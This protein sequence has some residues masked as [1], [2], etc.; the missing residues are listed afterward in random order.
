MKC[1]TCGWEFHRDCADCQA[2]AE[3]EEAARRAP[4][5]YHCEKCKEQR[6]QGCF[7]PRC[8]GIPKHVPMAAP[9]PTQEKPA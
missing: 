7:G 6:T 8:P 2:R 9:L 1:G 3:A 5:Y 4:F